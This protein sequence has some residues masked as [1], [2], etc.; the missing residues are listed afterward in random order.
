MTI[1]LSK[2]EPPKIKRNDIMRSTEPGTTLFYWVERATEKSV[3]IK[4]FES[5]VENGR[6]CRRKI[7]PDG[8]VFADGHR[9]LRW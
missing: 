6:I 5:Q 4:P 2:I 7:Y 9:L 8:S 1:I 3:W